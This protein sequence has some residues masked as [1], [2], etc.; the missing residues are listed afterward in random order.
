LVLVG[1]VG[2]TGASAG[3]CELD[4]DKVIITQGGFG[5]T[6]VRSAVD[7]TPG[8]DSHV[9]GDFAVPPD[10]DVRYRARA[11]KDTGPVVGQWVHSL[12]ASWSVDEGVWFKSITNPERNINLKLAAPPSVTR[13]QRRGLFPVA[14]AARSVA[15]SDVRSARE[16]EFVVQTTTEAEADALVTLFDNDPVVLVHA[17]ETYRFDAGYWSLGDLDEVHLSRYVGIPYRR[18]RVRGVEVDAPA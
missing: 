15:V 13:P 10:R 8:A 17:A 2:L 1:I 11:V 14:G 12:A 4:F 9:F 16:V 6:A 3:V 18:W 5:W 7:E